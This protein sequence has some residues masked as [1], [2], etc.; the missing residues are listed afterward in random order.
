MIGTNT[1]TEHPQTSSEAQAYPNPLTHSTTIRFTT[2]ER[3]FAQITIVN[4]L[5]EQVAKIFEGELEAG[6]HSFEWDANRMSG[7]P[8]AAGTYF[9]L[10]RE[11]A[12]GGALHAGSAVVPMV[13]AR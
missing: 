5:G 3:G 7:H 8:A 9:C 12:A 4:L 2:P 1:V 10:I 13:V 6:E 11:G